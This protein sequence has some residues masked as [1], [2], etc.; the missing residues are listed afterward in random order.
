MNWFWKIVML[1]D[2]CSLRS[3]RLLSLAWIE[4]LFYTSAVVIGPTAIEA[5]SR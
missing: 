5:I 2:Y 3:T 1:I 4:S